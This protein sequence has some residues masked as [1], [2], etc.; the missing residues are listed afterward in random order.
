MTEQILVPS[1]TRTQ[2]SFDDD[3]SADISLRYILFLAV[4]MGLGMNW[5]ASYLKISM[6]FVSVGIGP[7]AVLLISRQVLR[8][9]HGASRKNLTTILIAYGATQ[10]AEASV[11]LLFLIWL[12]TN[13][14]FFGLSF[15]PPWWLLPSPE[16]I[17][18]RTV[19][20][21]EWIVPLLV[22][23][24]LMLV[25]GF[26]GLVFGWFMKDSFVNDDETYPFPGVINQN[27]Q[28]GVLTDEA[29]TKGPLFWRLARWGFILALVT[30]LVPQLFIIDLS[31]IGQNSIFGIM[32]GPVGLALFAAGILIG[33]PKVSVTPF[34]VSTLLYTFLGI[35]LLAPLSVSPE[36]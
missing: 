30:V 4:I 15:V 16:V 22:H 28:V 2:P 24:F 14:A 7:M 5:L 32:L 1:H 12:A 33:K 29:Q 27:S 17:A 13:P 23:Y 8:R 36:S 31:N 21:P 25:P 6:G 11:G 35:F 34:F 9:K 20:T 18:N 19:F 3:Q 26:M 10:A